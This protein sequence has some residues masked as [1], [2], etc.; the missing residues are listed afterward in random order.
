MQDLENPQRPST[1]EIKDYYH[2]ITEK[3]SDKLEFEEHPYKDFYSAL[4]EKGFD[5]TYLQ[6]YATLMSNALKT[7]KN[8]VN[9]VIKNLEKLYKM[10]VIWL[11]IAECTGCSESL[12]RTEEPS[13]ESVLFDYL[14]LEY[15]ETLMVSSGFLAE[16]TLEQAI[17]KYKNHYVLIVEGAIPTHENDN[18]ENAFTSGAYATTGLEMIKK[19]SEHAMVILAIG[20]CSS[21]G[22]V[23][24]AYPNPTHSKALS[25]VITKE[26]INIAGCPPSE[27]NIIG[28]ILYFLIF[29]KAPSVD[30]FNRPLWAFS[31]RVHDI[32]NRRG[33]F[34]VGEFVE[35]F[36]DE[37]AIKGACLYMVGCK[38]PHVFN[39][40]AK[41][42]FNQKTSWPIQAGHGCIGCSEPHF[43]DTFAPLE[44]P[45]GNFK[46][47][48][49]RY[50]YPLT[51]YHQVSK[52]LETLPLSF[53]PLL[54][55]LKENYQYE[56]ILCLQ[57]DS[58]LPTICGLYENE[59]LNS[60]FKVEFETNP[61]LVYESLNKGS[62]KKLLINYE[63]KFP[64]LHDYLSHLEPI[65]KLSNNLFDFL[66][67]V[68]NILGYEKDLLSLAREFVGFQGAKIDYK[69]SKDTFDIARPLKVGMSFAIAKVDTITLSY[70]FLEF[71]GEFLASYFYQLS[72]DFG[73]NQILVNGNILK[74]KAFLLGFLG[75]IS[76]NLKID[77]VK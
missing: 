29:G 57:I 8:D 19:A 27:K 53:K 1:Q 66:E 69:I 42:R 39:N 59:T 41:M 21:F 5:K 38:G 35:S 67:V 7:P 25:E 34:D 4:L 60:C 11:H 76:S 23:Q 55:T 46:P 48:G 45:L 10:P 26:V 18:L 20:T 15:H 58:I 37:N 3:I 17:E 63:K 6:K 56:K 62:G 52:I 12:L 9:V 16:E 74:E 33:A 14:S 28:S 65:S 71:L 49:N 36:G 72:Q 13:I 75:H 68:K 44:T 54:E 30:R 51:T 24:S 31:Q 22:G 50:A 2:S 73:V 70:G 43:W 64:K 32:C 61:R 77:F 40:C 47:I